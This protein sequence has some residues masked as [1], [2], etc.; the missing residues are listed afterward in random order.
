MPGCVAVRMFTTHTSPPSFQPLL[1]I[2]WLHMQPHWFFTTARLPL[3]GIVTL[4]YQAPIS[5][6][7]QKKGRRLAWQLASFQTWPFLFREDALISSQ[8]VT[9][10]QVWLVICNV[11]FPFSILTASLYSIQLLKDE[12]QSCSL[13]RR[14][15]VT[16]Q[17]YYTC[18]T[19]Q[20]DEPEGWNPLFL[21]KSGIVQTM[22]VQTS[23]QS[24][25][26][27][28]GRITSRGEWV[29]HYPF[30]LSL[31]RL[32][33]KGSV[34]LV[35]GC[36]CIWCGYLSTENWAEITSS[37]HKGHQIEIHVRKWYVWL[38]V[39]D[40]KGWRESTIMVNAPRLLQYVLY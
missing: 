3:I 5:L 40:C 15:I 1:W 6:V 37:V 28:Y 27:W 19:C 25:Q 20:L 16:Q 11:C 33:T 17:I 21:Q 18:E 32:P 24:W 31:F 35:N 39:S 8:M 36:F 23:P 4:S 10:H 9:T 26:S 2:L 13:G 22:R 12:L 38:T 29:V 30:L 7:L 14:E 34:V